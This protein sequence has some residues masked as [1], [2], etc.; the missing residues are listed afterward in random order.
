MKRPSSSTGA[1]KAEVLAVLLGMLVEELKELLDWILMNGVHPLTS[2]IFHF[3][4]MTLAEALEVVG[5]CRLL[6][7][8]F[9]DDLSD[10]HRPL[11]EVHDD[12]ETLWIAERL[13]EFAV[14]G[15]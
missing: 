9:L 13:E 1:G 3:D 15:G 12:L 8:C 14:G 2:Y 4:E 6:E 11:H 7:T 10:V 5:G